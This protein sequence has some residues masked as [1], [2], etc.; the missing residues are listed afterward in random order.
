MYVGL[1]LRSGKNRQQRVFSYYM[2]VVPIRNLSV[3]FRSYYGIILIEFDCVSGTYSKWNGILV[4]YGL[5]EYREAHPQ[6][7]YTPFA[8][9]ITNHPRSAALVGTGVEQCAY[10]KPSRSC[11]VHP[12]P[13]FKQE[14]C[15][16]QRSVGF[17]DMRR[18]WR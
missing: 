10:K 8:E 12:L 11:G 6:T 15:H 16:N 17:P 13:C 18:T 7:W 9:L 5:R 2:C 3:S 14:Y 1:F 4:I